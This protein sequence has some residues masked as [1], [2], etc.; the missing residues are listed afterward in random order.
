MVLLQLLFL[1]TAFGGCKT[2][3]VGVDGGVGIWSY[4]AHDY[5]FG[6]VNGPGGLALAATMS[7]DGVSDVVV[8]PGAIKFRL[9]TGAILEFALIEPVPPKAVV[10][11]NTVKTF[12]QLRL[13]V[14]DAQ[15][16]EL[17]ASKVVAAEL[18]TGGQPIAMGQSDLKVEGKQIVK[19]ATCWVERQ[20]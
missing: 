16:T 11:G 14:T 10:V 4:D 12:W 8:V 13:P 2:K 7:V 9:E 15:L 6:V 5:H 3:E 18:P 17:A 20:E 1:G 19:S